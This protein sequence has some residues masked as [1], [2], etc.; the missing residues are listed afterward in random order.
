ML[1]S[2]VNR[3]NDRKQNVVWKHEVKQEFVSNGKEI[4]GRKMCRA[5]PICGQ[6]NYIL[7]YS[8]KRLLTRTLLA[9]MVPLPQQNRVITQERLNKNTILLEIML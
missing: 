9:K 3:A 4:D 2:Q 1:T 5:V 7:K 6:V 8:N